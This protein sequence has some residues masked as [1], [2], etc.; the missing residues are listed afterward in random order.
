MKKTLCLLAFLM[1]VPALPA[2]AGTLDDLLKSV[3][4]GK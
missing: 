3:F 2:R 4:G 1:I